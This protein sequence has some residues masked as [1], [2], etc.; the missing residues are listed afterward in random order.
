MSDL[1]GFGNL[2]GLKGIIIQIVVQIGSAIS[3]LA[4][5]KAVGKVDG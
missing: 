2:S 5:L 3:G 1:T 4:V